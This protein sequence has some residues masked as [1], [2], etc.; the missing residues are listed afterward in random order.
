MERASTYYYAVT[1]V[2]AEGV[3][4]GLSL[5]VSVTE[6]M[7]NRINFE[8]DAL[9]SCVLDTGNTIILELTTLSCDSKNIGGLS[10]IEHMVAVTTLNLQNNE[11]VD[12][13]NIGDITGL[14]IL[15]LSNNQIT[16]G[17]SNLTKLSA[18]ATISLLQN[19]GISCGE[20]N[21]II[22]AFGA[23]VVDPSTATDGVNCTAP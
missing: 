16:G 6:G 20:L 8:S 11:I 13:S 12:V 7:L 17:V 21:Q 14:E 9:R 4:S 19:T 15:D 3:E 1:A 2:S 10:G 5:E 23:S 22:G 18:P